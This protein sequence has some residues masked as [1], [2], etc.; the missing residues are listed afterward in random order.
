MA[1]EFLNYLAMP[2]RIPLGVW[3]A[4]RRGTIVVLAATAAAAFV[5]PSDTLT[6]FWGLG[7][8]LLP[9]VFL[10]APG[11]WRNV[12]PLAG[13]NQSPR[14]L[15]FARGRSAPRWLSTYGFAVST[16]LFFGI[17]LSRK[18]L[19][20]RNGAA[21]GVLLLA[22]MIGALVGGWL[23]KG[24]SG[25]CSSICPL[26]PVQRMYGQAPFV[27][28]P[29]AHCRPRLGCTTNCYDFNP[30]VAYVADIGMSRRGSPSPRPRSTATRS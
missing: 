11:S 17:A 3:R 16:V 18:V 4:V 12:C 5:D 9:L 28:V 13:L 19:F 14:E 25:W 22:V 23:L 26:L 30:R 24:K 29:N 8:P 6:A 7:V 2:S 21:L 27:G 10:V 15:G 1:V 20:N